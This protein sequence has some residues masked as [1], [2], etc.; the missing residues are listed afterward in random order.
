MVTGMKKKVC[1]FGKSTQLRFAALVQEVRSL[2]CF[3]SSAVAVQT[4]SAVDV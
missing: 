1:K 2:W 3:L 4:N